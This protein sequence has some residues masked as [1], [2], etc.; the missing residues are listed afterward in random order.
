MVVTKTTMAASLASMF[1]WPVYK[2]ILGVYNVNDTNFNSE[3]YG[4][5]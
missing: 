1:N 3:V 2:Y 5:G 4:L